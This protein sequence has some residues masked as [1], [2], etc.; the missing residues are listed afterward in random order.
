[1]N[2]CTDYISLT[3]TCFVN[4]LFCCCFRIV[5]IGEMRLLLTIALIFLFLCE[6]MFPDVV[7]QFCI[8]FL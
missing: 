8:L 7:Q 1:M 5:I 6:F 2:A 4:L 3:L